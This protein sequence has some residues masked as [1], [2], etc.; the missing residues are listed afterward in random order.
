MIKT[1]EEDQSSANSC[2]HTGRCQEVAIP[3]QCR[4]LWSNV[5]QGSAGCLSAVLPPD[6]GHGLRQKARGVPASP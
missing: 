6:S 5:V 1:Q 4:V 3:R 2:T